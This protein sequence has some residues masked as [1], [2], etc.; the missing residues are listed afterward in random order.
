MISVLIIWLYML[1]TAGLAGLLVMALCRSV[2]GYVPRDAVAPLLA[3]IAAVTVYAQIWSLFGGVG[4]AAN[5]CMCVC[6]I[7]M[8]IYCRKDICGL[9]K[10]IVRELKSDRLSVIVSLLLIIVMAYGASHGLMHYDTGLYH[11]QAI[12]WIEEYGSVPGL[13]NLHTRLG[14]NS[15]AFCLNALYGFAFTG[16]S[17]HVTGAFCALLLAWECAYLPVRNRGGLLC[18]SG[19]ARVMG[20]YY[21]LII[22]D[23]MVSPASDYYMVCL[24]FILVIR[25]MDTVEKYTGED[26]TDEALA[27]MSLLAVFSSFILTVKLSG[28]VF[29]LLA[30]LPGYRLLREHRE[31]EFAFCVGAGLTTVAPYLVRNVILSGW[32]WYP[33][34]ALG[35]FDADWRVPRDIASYDYREIQVYG[36]GF[37]DVSRFD[38]S[39][40]RWFGDWYAQMSLTDRL[41]ILAAI[42]GVA[43]FVLKCIYYVCRG[44]LHHE[45]RRLVSELF[46]EAVLCIGFVFWLLTSPLMR[47]GC[48]YVYLCDALLWGGM[49]GRIPADHKTVRFAVSIALLLLC[50]YKGIM[51]AAETAR[52]YRSDTWIRQQDYETF[53]VHAYEIRGDGT[54]VTVYA[55]DEGDRTGYD[56]FPSS[57]WDV[58]DTVMLRGSDIRAGFKPTE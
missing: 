19:L 45:P 14:Y 15:S 55:P 44:W 53:D 9:L 11:A 36:R 5:I 33:S 3:G 25:W 32:I 34:T 35:V 26:G 43:Y 30:I 23:E 38:E 17:Y 13:A 31:R 6:L 46:P 28:A 50:M 20:I 7:L 37:T 47:Y 39:I 48:L 29:V 24:G 21:L 54:T 12:R 41:L 52:A 2:T 1:L 4:M 58:S 51:F 56:P 16:Q 18:A 40:V 42:V 10:C 49:I 27:R 8:G 57:P 22:F